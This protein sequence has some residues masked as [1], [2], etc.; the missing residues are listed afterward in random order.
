VRSY[1]LLNKEEWPAL[2]IFYFSYI[3]NE[4][5]LSLKVT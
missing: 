2:V 3:H 1:K 5:P 4:F